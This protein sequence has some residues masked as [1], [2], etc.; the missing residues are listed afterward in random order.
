MDATGL[1]EDEL[2]LALP[3]APMHEVCPGG[4]A[5]AATDDAPDTGRPSPFAALA[6]LKKH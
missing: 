3:F 2:I 1:V 5:D 6:R 4:G